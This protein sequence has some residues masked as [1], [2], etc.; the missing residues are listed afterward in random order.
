[1]K[2]FTS[3]LLISALLHAKIIFA[4]GHIES[5]PKY[6]RPGVT[7]QLPE[8]ECGII[9]TPFKI[10]ACGCSGSVTVNGIQYNISVGYTTSNESG[11]ASTDACGVQSVYVIIGIA[12]SVPYQSTEGAGSVSAVMSICG[13]SQCFMAKNQ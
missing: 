3:L 4:R 8:N 5:Y 6:N 7:F 12:G 2:L 1:M 11:C 10:T 13:V 9:N